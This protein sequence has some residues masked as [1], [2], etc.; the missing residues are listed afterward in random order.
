MDDVSRG[1]DSA[2]VER[3]NDDGTPQADPRELQ[4]KLA[5]HAEHMIERDKLDPRQQ[6]YLKNAFTGLLIRREKD[7]HRA[8]ENHHPVVQITYNQALDLYNQE[9]AAK[10]AALKKVQHRK[11]A[12]AAR[13]RNR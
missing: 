8:L 5:E 2:T 4:R 6:W 13:K 1:T 12:K 11:R 10:K 9:E 3:K 7:Y